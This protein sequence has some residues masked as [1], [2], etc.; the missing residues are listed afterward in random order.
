M[1]LI[2][3]VFREEESLMDKEKKMMMIL[4]NKDKCLYGVCVGILFI[5]SL[6]R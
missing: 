4:I 6:S 5:L 3:F 2:G 1:E